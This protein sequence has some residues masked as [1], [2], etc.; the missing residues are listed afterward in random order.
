[1]NEADLCREVTQW[2]SRGFHVLSVTI[3][4]HRKQPANL[5]FGASTSLTKRQASDKAPAAANGTADQNSGKRPIPSIS[6]SGG[7][8]GSNLQKWNPDFFARGGG[9]FAFHHRRERTV[10]LMTL[11]DRVS[12]VRF[13]L[14]DFDLLKCIGD[15]LA[16]NLLNIKLSRPSLQA[17]EM[18]SFQSMSAFFVHDLKNTASTCL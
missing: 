2:V 13:S 6:I 3:L 14:E 12:G 11:G 10:G 18:E 15:Q 9:R 16:A 5:L 8:S 7:R 1:M 4:A 17:K